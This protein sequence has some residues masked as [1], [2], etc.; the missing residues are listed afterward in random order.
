MEKQ[1]INSEQHADEQKQKVDTGLYCLVMIAQYHGIAAD[2]EQIRHAYAIGNDG[3]GTIDI[4]RAAK[5]MGL[6]AKAVNVEYERLQRLQLPAI[7]EITTGN[8]Q[9]AI[10]DREFAILA[11]VEGEQLLILHPAENKPRVMKKD[12]FLSLWTGDGREAIKTGN[13]QE[14]IGNKMIN[15]EER[16]S[17][18]AYG[19]LPKGK[20]ILFALRGL[21]SF[22]GE[23]FGIKW[24]IPAIWKY[25]GPLSEVLI[26][27][28]V[29]QIFGLVTPIFTQV[30][31]DKVLVHRGITT[32]DV[33]AIGLAAIALF[34]AILSILRTYVFTHTTS[35]ID[36]TLGTKLFKHLFAL[37]LRYFEVRRVGDT[38]A[39]VRELEN[40][41][42]FLTGAPLT[43]VLDVM[44]MV[45]FIAVMLFYSVKLTF[46]ALAALPLFAGLSAFVTP[47]LRHRLD[48]RFN[49]GA[50][51]QSYL[52]EAVGG[53]QTVKSFALEP[54]VQKK[55]EGLLS[56]YIK[57]SF[58]TYQLSGT[59]GAIGQF[60]HR[61]SYLLILWVGAH[62]VMDGNLT[63]GQLI[64]FQMLSARVSDPVLRLVQMWQEFQQAGLS[65]KRLGDIFNAKPE[66]ATD[67]AK[68]RLPAIKGNV[69]LE[70]VRFRYRVDGPEV[71]RNIAF[72]IQ[73]GMTVGIV[74]RSGSG[75]STV[76]KLIQ[77]LYIPE[78]G[79][80]LIDGIDI[81]LAD[82]A[83]LR[84]QI[85]VVLQE[86]FL[87]NGSVRDN[88]AIHY[89][90]ASMSDIVR[91]AQLAG[92][93]DFILELPE[94]YDTM[95]GEKG[96]ALS[97]G[98]RQRVAIARALLTNPRL[99][100]FDEATSA[101]DY[102]SES[103]IQR[104]MKKMCHGRTVIII[105][106]R[107]ST[108]RDAEM[109]FVI[110]KGELIEAGS[111]EELVAQKGLYHY[112]YSQQ[113]KD[114]GKEG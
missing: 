36:V 40:I 109:I 39:R 7:V 114:D 68:A 3:A 24:F 17:P 25:R 48:E 57:A 80:I 91:V 103:I 31:I 73:P 1:Y 94:G 37:P 50:D 87:F 23:G 81:S 38:V 19:L 58:K 51:A 4:L 12:E 106:H 83:W 95:V 13:R 28:L 92:A 104:N 21:K 111:H 8:G 44:F 6:K 54:Q 75:K 43:S 102:E 27:S 88:I 15:K 60:I 78:S 10:G 74:G 52:V 70:G 65:I 71:L 67:S 98:Q 82:P 69:R 59:A 26:A 61:S 97:G 16:L 113:Y 100:I 29:L 101:L 41:R 49:K 110:D 90:S 84:R 99:L 76:T 93:H 22:S 107:L 63:V 89:P 47:M 46:V 32:L 86:N 55:W 45:V 14:A 79:R 108:L 11:K 112:L 62:L 72:D 2:A 66:P 77:R 105:A 33:L 85:G 53:V 42:Q 34:E 35:R 64:A 30:I 20:I 5:D 18:I 96:A 9:E 56:D